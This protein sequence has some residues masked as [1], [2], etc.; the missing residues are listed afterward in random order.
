VV[1]A[2]FERDVK[3]GSA[4]GLTRCGQRVDLGVCFPV[5]LVPAGADFPS[6]ANDHGA[7]EGIRLHVA[8]AALGQF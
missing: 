1:A 7:N 2:R 5:A 8:P 3:R 4:G 6:V